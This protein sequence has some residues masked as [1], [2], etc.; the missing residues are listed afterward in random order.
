MKKVPF[1]R[2]LALG[3]AIMAAVASGG[4]AAA[5][6]TDGGSSDVYQG[7]LNHNIGAL[8]N[9]KVNP[10]SPPRCLNNDTVISWN[11]TGPAGA[12]GPQGPK[13]DPGPAGPQGPKGD[14]GP[15]GPAGAIGPAGPK[16]DTGPAGAAGA[17]GP[18][19]PQGPKGD[20]GPAGPAGPQG[21]QGP[22]G[23]GLGG[24]YWH[25]H[26][27]TMA[28]GPDV[29]SI[30]LA[31]NGSDQAYG[32]GAW[33]ENPAGAQEITEDAPS[34]DLSHWYVEATNNDPLNS[35]TLHGYVLCGPAG[36]SYK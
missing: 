23:T 11:Q 22:A 36:L 19:G 10:T 34:G 12:A 26:Q 27:S 7:C 33:I 13:G 6:A 20:T 35:Y 31:C 28:T 24:M 30:T 4:T 29:A 18:T 3:G 21:P 8:Y 5:L 15:A 14:T 16:G 1:G 17:T 9:V 32:G 25:T 2:R